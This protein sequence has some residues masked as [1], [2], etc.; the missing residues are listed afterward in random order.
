MFGVKAGEGAAVRQ[1][2]GGPYLRQCNQDPLL[3]ADSLPSATGNDLPLVEDPD[4]ELTGV[5][6]VAD[7]EREQLADL[8]QRG[9]AEDVVGL[10]L[11]H[12]LTKVVGAD[13]G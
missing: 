9:E 10:G 2:P 5:P 11:P 3:R 7:Q 12:E 1:G 6:E 13:L 8:A 4:P